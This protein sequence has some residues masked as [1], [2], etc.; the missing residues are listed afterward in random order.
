VGVH[1]PT[2]WLENLL[3]VAPA[4]DLFNAVL[5]DNDPW[6]VV[7]RRGAQLLAIG[8]VPSVIA[9]RLLRRLA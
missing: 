2:Q 8:I 1:G 5:F 3:P 9:T 4:R 6:P 7:L